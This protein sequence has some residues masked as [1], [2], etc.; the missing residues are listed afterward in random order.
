M[1]P[2]G[3]NHAEDAFLEKENEMNL[4]DR[5]IAEVGRHLPEKNRADIEAEIRSMLEDML[6]ERG[7]SAQSADD[8]LIAEILEQLGDPKLLAS[9]YAPSQRYLIGP[10]WYEVYV[11][12]LQRVLYIVL[13]I[14][15]AVTFI[16]T[17]ADNPL[18]FAEALG[19][20][21]GG[22]FDVGLQILFWITVVFVLLERSDEVPYQTKSIESNKWTIAQLPKTP[23]KR[24]ISIGEALTDIVMDLFVFLW[25]VLPLFQNWFQSDSNPV[26]F[27][28][29]DLWNVWLPVFFVLM[30]MNLIHDAFKLKIGNWTPTLTA[31]NVLLCLASII[32]I[33]ALVTTQQVINPAFLATLDS[34]QFSELRNVTTW[35]TWTVNISAAILVG[36]LLWDM[37]NSMRLARRLN[38]QP[39]LVMPAKSVS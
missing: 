13:P 37:V 15:A 24:Q 2:H 29:P 26:P 35:A 1:V 21:F 10:S 27:L 18:D 8:K 20:A 34:T 30:T 33:V 6:E 19:E 23:H 3:R 17:L 38:E 39:G 16:L 28:N 9:Q 25:I 31:T 4:V 7:K 5:Y 32:Y 14:F 11:Q 12:T 22:A 36:I